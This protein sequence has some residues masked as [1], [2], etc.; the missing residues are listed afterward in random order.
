MQATCAKHDGIAVFVV[1]SG[2]LHFVKDWLE[3][4]YTSQDACG[5]FPNTM[6][7]H[8][9][10]SVSVR[11]HLEIVSLPLQWR[12]INNASWLCMEFFDKNCQDF[13]KSYWQESSCLGL[14]IVWFEG[15][16]ERSSRW[17]IHQANLGCNIHQVYDGIRCTIQM[18]MVHF[19]LQC[20]WWIGGR[21]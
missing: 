7:F 18:C 16:L 2:G 10:L 11:M 6:N 13:K 12:C 14:H 3:I 4:L 21:T 8:H 20:T 9:R 17:N 15:C 1:H 5:I 19:I